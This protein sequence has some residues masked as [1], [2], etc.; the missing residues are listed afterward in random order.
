MYIDD[1]NFDDFDL[2]DKFNYKMKSYD[3]ILID[4]NVGYLESNKNTEISFVDFK[5][6]NGVSDDIY[7][8]KEIIIKNCPRDILSL[9]QFSFNYSKEQD[10]NCLGELVDKHMKIIS[11]AIEQNDFIFLKAILVT[12]F[13]SVKA[14]FLRD[15]KEDDKMYFEEAKVN[16]IE[17]IW[18]V[19]RCHSTRFDKISTMF[20]A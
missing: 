9:I 1:Y 20:Q 5:I 6:S 13:E 4:A 2:S 8:E 18:K 14:E 16:N 10:L 19:L 17:D 7:I 15:C 3:V 12:H 11:E